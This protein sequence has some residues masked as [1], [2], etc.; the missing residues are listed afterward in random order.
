LGE[1]VE[2]GKQ[3]DDRKELNSMTCQTLKDENGK[4]VGFVCSRGK[5]QPDGQ[6]CYICGQP[7]ERY[8]DQLLEP[9]DIGKPAKTCDKPMCRAHA[10]RIGQDYDLCRE[11][12]H[13][14]EKENNAGKSDA[15]ACEYPK[16]L[17]CDKC[18]KVY[19]CR[20][21]CRVVSTGFTGKRGLET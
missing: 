9:L 1:E 14:R 11:H 5:K 20:L 8:C 10:Y 2:S 7:S 3:K 4:P 15:K 16:F 17:L 18:P 21:S 12:F 19:G 6:P 13:Q